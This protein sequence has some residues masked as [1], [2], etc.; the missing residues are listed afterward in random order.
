MTTGLLMVGALFSTAN[1]EK[2]TDV[3]GDGMYYRLLRTH[4]YTTNAWSDATGSTSATQ[5]V[6]SVN[7]NG[8]VELTPKANLTGLEDSK[9]SIWMIREVTNLPVAYEKDATADVYVQLING[10]GKTLKI[11]KTTNAQP[12]NASVATNIVDIFCAKYATACNTDF[13]FSNA[14][15]RYYLTHAATAPYEIIATQLGSGVTALGFDAEE[16]LE[17]DNTKAWEA[18]ELNSQLGNGFALNIP[19][20]DKLPVK[21]NVF[22][23]VL[24]AIPTSAATPTSFYLQNE[25]GDYI[26]LSSAEKDLWSPTTN[27]DQNA[28]KGYQFKTMN[29]HTFANADLALKGAATFSISNYYVNADT[30][31]LIVTTQVSENRAWTTY[32]LYIATVG[33]IQY[34]TAAPAEVYSY[35]APNSSYP[36]VTFGDGNTVSIKDFAGKVWNIVLKDDNAESLQV[37]SPLGGYYS[38]SDWYMNGQVTSLDGYVNLFIPEAQVELGKPEGQWLADFNNGFTFVNRES[39]ETFQLANTVVRKT[40]KKDQYTISYGLLNGTEMYTVIIS[41]VG[42]PGRT[43]NGYANFDMAKEALN[44]KYLAFYNKATDDSIYVA[45]NADDEVYLTKDKAEAIEFRVKEVYHDFTD[46]SGLDYEGLAGTDTLF[47]ITSYLKKAGNNYVEGKDTLQFYHYR[48]FEQFGEKYLTYDPHNKKFE[49]NDWTYN[50]DEDFNSD[51]AFVLKEKGTAY[52]IIMDY[53]LNYPYENDH[54]GEASNAL[55]WDNYINADLYTTNTMKLYAGN[56][57]AELKSMEKIYNYNDNDRIS[58]VAVETPEYMTLE[59][60]KNIKVYRE[61]D[62]NVMMYEQA[63]NYANFFLGMENLSDAAYA[64]AK[65]AMFVDTAYVRN[66]TYRPQYLLAVRAN[67]VGEEFCSRPDLHAKLHKDT[68]Y[69]EF[70]VNLVDSAYAVG[71]NKKSNPFTY[72]LPSY[73]RLGFVKAIHTEDALY[74][75]NAK[76]VKT[77]AKIDLSK[78]ADQVAT[79]AFRYVDAAREGVKMETAYGQA[80]KDGNRERGWIKWHNGI[81]VVTDEYSEAEVFTVT[82]TEEVATSTDNIEAA[83]VIVIAGEG[84]VIVK[85]AEGKKVA[86]ANVLGQQIANTVIT[87][88]EATIATPAGIVIVSVEGEAAVKA[89]VK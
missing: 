85:G 2:V 24:K 49:L 86:I 78:N 55:T 87:S 28:K 82:P 4:N 40:D 84:K 35:D 59:A 51:N 43:E 63:N 23:G 52:N 32:Q 21:G 69:G 18:S 89:I 1:A 46:H 17:A 57:T 20:S 50:K 54:S 25:N 38:S 30:D 33:G 75:V 56:Q 22:E 73:H 19:F 47:H 48:L 34:L 79:F 31:S 88:N 76:G 44:G 39:G 36:I 11:D 68:T 53:N 65:G 60:F 14:G 6:L 29:A 15:T 12:T 9:E 83:N 71:I 13:W 37:L 27:L 70:L 64:K 81:P 5:Y 45:K 26:Y 42:T 66:N 10:E 62:N 7:Q 67:H 74:P 77:G 61:K 41:E 3:A 58:L 8:N 72:D 80:D 16:L